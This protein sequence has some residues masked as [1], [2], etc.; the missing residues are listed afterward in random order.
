MKRFLL[1]LVLISTVVALTGC[2]GTVSSVSFPAG[3]PWEDMG[4]GILSPTDDL[5]AVASGAGV[6]A[7]LVPGF[8]DSGLQAVVA[9]GGATPHIVGCPDRACD[10]QATCGADPVIEKRYAY[11]LLA[12]LD[13]GLFTSGGVQIQDGS[14]ATKMGLS[15]NAGNAGGSFDVAAGFSEG[16]IPGV[17]FEDYD[18]ARRHRAG[19]PLARLRFRRDHGADL[20]RRGL[21]NPDRRTV[22]HG[23][24]H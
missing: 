19:P 17:Q 8:I 23:R 24:R 16:L 5:V 7:D 11:T 3:S 4:T 14:G 13:R 6:E 15:I 12:H 18:E 21:R 22:R 9:C 2:N 20:P 1:S 10:A